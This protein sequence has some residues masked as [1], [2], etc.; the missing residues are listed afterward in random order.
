MHILL[1]FKLALSR[2]QIR[3][4]SVLSRFKRRLFI[5]RDINGPL[6]AITVRFRTNLDRTGTEQA[7]NR[8]WNWNKKKNINKNKNKN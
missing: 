4:Y 6:L 3:I 1:K 5:P 2:V 7:Q 8:N